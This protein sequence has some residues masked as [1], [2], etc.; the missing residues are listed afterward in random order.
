MFPWGP[1]SLQYLKAAHFFL[2]FPFLGIIR[3]MVTYFAGFFVSLLKNRP[4]EAKD[5]LTLTA[6]ILLAGCNPSGQ[7]DELAVALDLAGDNRSELQAVLDHYSAPRDSLKR[8]A[9]EYLIGNMAGKYTVSSPALE[10][11]E[12]LLPEIAQV[13]ADE[14]LNSPRIGNLFAEF[15]KKRSPYGRHPPAQTLRP[16]NHPG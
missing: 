2:S 13:P 3:K 6:V 15:R 5:F 7:G 10:A 11:Y 4:H 8:R 1:I 14:G 12:E 9:A 16:G